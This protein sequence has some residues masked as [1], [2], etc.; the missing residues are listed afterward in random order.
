MELPSK[1]LKQIA[2]IARPKYE[3]KMLIVIDKS[4]QEEHFLNHYKQTVGISCYIFN[5]LQWNF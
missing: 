1:I 5:G 4:I 2:F 3:E